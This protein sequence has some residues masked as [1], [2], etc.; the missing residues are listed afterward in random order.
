MDF[1]HLLTLE[2]LFLMICYVLGNDLRSAKSVVS[3]SDPGPS[4]MAIP[5]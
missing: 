5:V 1:I 2:I 4:P 3:K